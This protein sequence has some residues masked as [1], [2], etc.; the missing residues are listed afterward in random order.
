VRERIH[1]LEKELERLGKGRQQRRGRRRKTATPV[2][3]IIGYTN[4]G[5]TTLFNL[6]TRS[7]FHVEERLFATLDTATR[8]LRFTTYLTPG[9]KVREVVITDTVG[10]IKDL[11]KDLMVAFRPTF[12]ELQESDLLIHLEDISNPAFPDHIEAVNKIL[13]ELDLGHIPRLLVF[14]KEDR[15]DQKEVETICHKFG[16][17]SISALRPES[18]EKFFIALEKKLWEERGLLGDTD[19]KISEEVQ[20]SLNQESANRFFRALTMSG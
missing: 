4:A 12:D 16:G 17:V 5:K 6:L 3:S 19:N 8:K 7:H 20:Q 15:L 18:F 9:S 10:L 13:F 2:V 14:N 11:P 1:L